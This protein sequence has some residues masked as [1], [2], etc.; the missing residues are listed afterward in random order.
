M[1]LKA[2]NLHANKKKRR[3]MRRVSM[4]LT[5]ALCFFIGIALGQVL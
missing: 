2:R 5:Y 3:Q 1:K 4:W